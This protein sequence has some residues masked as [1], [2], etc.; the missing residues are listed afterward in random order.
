MESSLLRQPNRHCDGN[1]EPGTFQT[2][3]QTT[4]PRGAET[5]RGDLMQPDENNNPA[6]CD[7]DTTTSQIKCAVE[8]NNVLRRHRNQL[9]LY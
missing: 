4:F 9:R 3:G 6:T 7:N 8:I 5:K 1:R 2:I